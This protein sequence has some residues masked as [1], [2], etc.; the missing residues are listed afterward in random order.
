MKSRRNNLDL[1]PININNKLKLFSEHWSPKIIAKMNDYDFKI[2]K[3]QGEFVWH[4]HPKTDETFIV[5][6][7]EMQIQFRDCVVNI[8]EGEMLVVPRGVEHKPFAQEECHIL[9][10]EL[11]GTINT[12][13]TI[14]LRTIESSA[15]I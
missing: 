1:H 15:W 2:A 7:G 3:I 6:H 5:I 8:S 11:V 4:S 12:G 10:I 9:L 13:N 14:D